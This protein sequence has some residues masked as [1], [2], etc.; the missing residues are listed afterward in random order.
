MSGVSAPQFPVVEPFGAT[1]GNPADITLPIPIAPAVGAPPA[2]ASFRDGFP[3]ATRIDPELGGQPPYGQD[4]NG[5]LY[6]L[7][8]YC[9]LAQ[10][11][12]RVP[13]NQTAC[14]AFGGY[15]LGAELASVTTPGR[16]W[17][18]WLDGN[19]HDPD[20]DD[21]GWAAS[22]PLYATDT[23]AAGIYNDLA[24][25]GASNLALDVDTT[26]GDVTFT[27]AIAQRAGQEVTWSNTGP[28]L[29]ILDSSSS[30]GGDTLVTEGGGV[31][32]TEGG[33]PLITE[34]AGSGSALQN[35]FRTVAGGLTIASGQSLT[36]KYFA[37]GL[38]RW[39][40]L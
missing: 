34:G 3:A 2:T 29:L 26:A 28:N 30:G 27:G 15:K 19:T 20:V 39:L 24:L 12:Q 33:S 22:D 4:M 17:T 9:A 25:P 40:A 6:M 1:A 37:D 13:F 36:M 7:S 21:T 5:I 10:A 31:L 32:V 35:R 38:N 8:V 14:D 18:N 23:P 11:G 16:I